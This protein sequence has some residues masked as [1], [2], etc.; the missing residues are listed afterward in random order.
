MDCRGYLRS[1]PLHSPDAICLMCA[2]VCMQLQSLWTLQAAL[3]SLCS[4]IAYFSW[5]VQCGKGG[6]GGAPAGVVFIT[7]TE[8]TFECLE[9][10]VFA[11]PRQEWPL[12]ECMVEGTTIFLCDTTS[13]VHPYLCS[14]QTCNKT[15]HGTTMRWT[16]RC[17]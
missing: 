1:P 16:W 4:S 11:M 2:L 3:H 14:H 7:Q 10:M 17:E 6:E 13:Q 15:K 5:P 8:G 9:K 12:V